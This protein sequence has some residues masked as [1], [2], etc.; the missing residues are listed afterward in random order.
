MKWLC[1]VV[2]VDMKSIVMLGTG[3]DTMGGVSAVVNVYRAA[4]LFDRFSIRYLATHADGGKLKKLMAMVRAWFSLLFELLAGR[5]SILHVHVA[6][7]ASFWR[8]S[9]FFLLA[10]VFRVPA[11]LHLHGGHF[12]MFYGDECGPLRQ[13]FIRYVFNRSAYVVVLSAGWR[14]WVNSI[15]NNANVVTIFNPVVM[16]AEP[17]PWTGRHQGEVLFLGRL[18]QG[19][20]S[21]DLLEAAARVAPAHQSLRLKLGG[22]GE[23][24]ATAERA[25]QLGIGDKVDVLGWVTGSDKARYLAGSYIY[26][27]PSYAEGLPMSVLEAMAAGLPVLTTPVG[28][29]P[30][31]ITDGVEGF[32][33]KPG[34]IDTLARRLQSLLDDDD[35]AR[36]MGAA[37]RA[38]VA[39]TFSSSA[40]LPALEQI[41][42]ELGVKQR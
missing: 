38:K 33:V 13:R 4:G 17:I 6:S 25:A 31:A 12:A 26:A 19:K 22:D 1:A 37:A 15:S 7:R 42:L 27:L 21:Y 28:G 14:I 9:L 16:P 41:Y 35:L 5:V 34:D 3:F 23:L 2:K 29:I 39:S 24:V 30:E 10:F 18:G 20:G 11:I 36:R 32:L 8:K 40:V